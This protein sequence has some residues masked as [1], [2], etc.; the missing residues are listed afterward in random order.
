ME[1]FITFFTQ[2]LGKHLSKEGVIFLISVF[3]VLELRG[4]LIAASL[5][6][7]PFL[8]GLLISLIGNVLPIPFVLLFFSKI[9]TLLEKFSYTKPLAEWFREKVD[10]NKKNIEKYDFWG[11][12]LFVG[13]PIP[14]TGAWTG[15]MVASLLKMN[16]KKSILAIFLGILLASL[17]MS[18]LSYG[19]LASV[20]A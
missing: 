10:K 7:V 16:R 18:V 15:A 14:G 19:I 12:A 6:K 3:P 5:L 9:V 13:I 8:K 11:L 20:V 4:G 2:F 1:S 17:I